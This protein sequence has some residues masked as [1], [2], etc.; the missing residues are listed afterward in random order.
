MVAAAACRLADQL[1]REL[2]VNN[3]AVLVRAAFRARR[4]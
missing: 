2:A 3:F 4:P 1:Q